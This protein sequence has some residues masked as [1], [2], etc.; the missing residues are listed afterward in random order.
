MKRRA[1]TA[2]AGLC[3]LGGG[4]SASSANAAPSSTPVEPA[5][6]SL[7]DCHRTTWVCLWGGIDYNGSLIFVHPI[8]SGRCHNVESTFPYGANSVWNRGNITQRVWSEPNCTGQNYRIGT[9]GK[10]PRSPF[11]IKGLGGY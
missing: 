6:A 11:A 5:P 9:N 3:L 10:V 7:A 4:L 2:I 8:P 1:I